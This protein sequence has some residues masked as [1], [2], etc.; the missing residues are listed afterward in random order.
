MRKTGLALAL[1]LIS[2]VAL[3]GPTRYVTSD[4]QIDMRSGPTTQHRI[5]KFLGS[6]EAVESVEANTEGW[7][8]VRTRGGD[9]GWVLSRYLENSPGYKE[10]L[11][12]A[13]GNVTR[14][15]QEVQQLRTKLGEETQ[16]AKTA[17][18]RGAELSTANDQMKQQ[19][20]EAGRGLALSQE[21][22]ELKLQLVD[23]Q[24][25]IQE[26]K[27]EVVRLGDRSQ[28]DWFV[29]GAAVVFAGFIVGIVVTRI[30][31]QRKSTWGNL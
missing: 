24:R 28:R 9:E 8:L 30:R 2:G 21:N 5:V 7:T 23:A 20:T 17:E 6:G 15:Q 29:T 22:K 10:Q 18:S 25:D 4:L 16:R 26:L 11:E 19:L 13:T 12:R 31:W 27:S 1:A 14:L 3:A